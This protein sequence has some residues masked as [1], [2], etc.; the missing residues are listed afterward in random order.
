MNTG[1]QKSGL[2]PFGAKTTTTPAGHNVRGNIRPKKNMFEIAAAHDI[3][4]AAT[5]TVGYMTDFL[6]KVKK[7]SEIKGT[8]Y[9]HVIAPCP[10]GWGVAVNE[11]VDIAREIVDCGLWYLAEYENG[12][13]TLTHDPKEFTDVSAYLRKQGR[14]R[15][16]TDEDIA[17]ITESRDKKWN[18]IRS[19]WNVK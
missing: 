3:P 15:H 7:A 19:Q 5:A 16:L 14:F 8:K 2:T 13:F 10:T 18:R 11:T 17:V 1:I 12:E 6:N 9:I 4:Y